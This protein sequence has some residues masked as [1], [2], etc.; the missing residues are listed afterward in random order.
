MNMASSPIL[1]LIII[2]SMWLQISHSESTEYVVA[3]SQN[4]W[5]VPFPSRHALTQWASSHQFIDTM[6]FDGDNKVN[7]DEYTNCNIV[8][9]H[10]KMGIKLDDDVVVK[11]K[12]LVIP[13]LITLPEPPSP[14][15][16]PNF[17]GSNGGVAAGLGLI[18]WL[19]VSSMAMIM[20]LI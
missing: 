19:G 14:A 10:S 16:A 13:P 8:E 20:F 15:P 3:D 5:K 2:F 11:S 7:E 9:S 17:S 18:M 6:L 1:M 12:P 4:S